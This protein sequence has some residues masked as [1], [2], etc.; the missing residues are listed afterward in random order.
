MQQELLGMAAGPEAL[1][2]ARHL[3]LVIYNAFNDSAK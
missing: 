1:R 2:G 3:L